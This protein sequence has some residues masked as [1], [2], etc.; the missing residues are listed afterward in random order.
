[1]AFK[2]VFWGIGV[3]ANA[4][5]DDCFEEKSVFFEAEV[6]V[7]EDDFYARI[8]VEGSGWVGGFVALVGKHVAGRL[9]FPL[10]EELEE[11]EDGEEDSD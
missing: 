11:S 3:F 6:F 5:A 8:C 2:D 4:R 1:M 7:A 10:K 9:V